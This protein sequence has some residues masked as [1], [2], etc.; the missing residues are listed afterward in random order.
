MSDY[1][2]ATLIRPENEWALD[3]YKSGIARLAPGP[4]RVGLATTKRIYNKH[5]SND[6]AFELVDLSPKGKNNNSD[7][8]SHNREQLRQWFLNNC[9]EDYIFWLDG[10]VEII[11]ANTV[12]KSINISENKD[13]RSYGVILP[14]QKDKNKKAYYGMKS[15]LMHRSICPC[16]KF[17]S[18]KFIRGNN[19]YQIPESEVYLQSLKEIFSHLSRHSSGYLSRKNA[20]FKIAYG[21]IPLVRHTKHIEYKDRQFIDILKR[22]VGQNLSQDLH[23]ID[24]LDEN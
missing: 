24:V 21:E 13:N 8:I 7:I 2:I 5:F 10:D 18:A 12:L 9:S 17:F 16:A 3:A 19:K 11:Y 6:S 1:S 20:F 23:N 4:N 15:T 14:V 22:D